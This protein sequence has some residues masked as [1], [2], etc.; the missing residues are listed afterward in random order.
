MK[1]QIA[2]LLE[3][4]LSLSSLRHLRPKPSSVITNFAAI[5]TEDLGGFFGVEPSRPRGLSTESK[6]ITGNIN[7]IRRLGD[8]GKIPA[9]IS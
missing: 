3:G 4:P 2:H 8:R 1:I 7:N 5:R 6:E 9:G